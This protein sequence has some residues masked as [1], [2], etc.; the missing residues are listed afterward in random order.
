M[1]GQPRK[2]KL[3]L[4]WVCNTAL[5]SK[6]IRPVTN[7]LQHFQPFRQIHQWQVFNSHNDAET[8]IHSTTISFSEIRIFASRALMILRGVGRSA[9]ILETSFAWVKLFK[10]GV[11]PQRMQFICT[12]LHII[13]KSTMVS[14]QPHGHVMGHAACVCADKS[15]GLIQQ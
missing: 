5:S 12:Q 4:S 13:F 11:T 1:P 7:E 3:E 14:T 8:I 6:P 2:T 15:Q 10:F 9:P